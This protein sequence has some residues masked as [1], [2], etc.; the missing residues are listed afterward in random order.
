MS[1]NSQAPKMLAH[2]RLA[3]ETSRRYQDLLEKD[4]AAADV[5]K[6]E[7]PAAVEALVANERITGAQREAVAEKI[8]TDHVACIQLIRDIAKHRNATELDAIGGPV[9]GAEKTASDNP[10]T[11]GLVADHDETEAGKAYRRML[12]GA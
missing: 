2:L 4:A 11:G 9:R 5:V 6:A 7:V 3:N 10:I 8:A 12:T 1:D